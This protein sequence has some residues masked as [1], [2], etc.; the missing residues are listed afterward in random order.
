MLVFEN[1]IPT[2]QRLFTDKVKTISQQLGID[3]NW[4]MVVMYAESRLNHRAVN[5]TSNATGLIQFMP[6]TAKSLNT[7]VE[8]LKAMTNIDQLDIVYQYYLP[9]RY[10]MKSV[11]DLYL[12]TFFPLA[13]GKPDEWI[14]RSKRLSAKLIAQQNRI[15]DRNRNGEITVAEF[16]AY[17]DHILKQKNITFEKKKNQTPTRTL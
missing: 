8:Q 7:S 6:N 17:V 3:P 10:R 14:M 1:H 13:I 12:A 15:I 16:K 4:L 2:H 5:P 9:Y 11:Y